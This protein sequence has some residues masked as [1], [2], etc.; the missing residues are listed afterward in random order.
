MA[1]VEYDLGRSRAMGVPGSINFASLG[2]KV[3]G[4]TSTKGTV[5]DQLSGDTKRTR[6]TEQN[7]VEVHLRET[8]VSQ[9]H[10]RVSID[11][12]PRVLGFTSLRNTCFVSYAF[13]NFT[14]KFAYLEENARN[15]VVDLGDKLEERVVGE[16]LECKL[17]LGG[18][19]RVG[20]PEDSV[21]VSGDNLA[22]VEGR[23]DVFLNSLVT[24]VGTDLA[25]HP[26]Q[27]D[28]YFL[29]SKTVE[30]TRET[31]QRG[32]EGEERVR[33]GGA[34]KLASVSRNV[35]SLVIT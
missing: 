10:T 8:I 31:V 22:T 28:E 34:D 35:S 23:P 9:K 19:T 11:I 14:H 24:G 13:E 12:R 3:D 16:M 29:V 21:T 27:P 18:V 2:K 5:P 6:N 30:R 32:T 33:E 26:C 7:G 25:L 1:A 17:A 4:L 15:E 20:L